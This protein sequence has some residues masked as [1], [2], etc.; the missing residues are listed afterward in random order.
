MRKTFAAYSDLTVWLAETLATDHMEAI[1]EEI[2]LQ[3]GDVCI[4]LG[5]THHRRVIC[6]HL[7]EAL[8]PILPFLSW[9]MVHTLEQSTC[10]GDFFRYRADNLLGDL[11]MDGNPPI[12]TILTFTEVTVT[13]YELYVEEHHTQG[14]SLERLWRLLVLHYFA[15]SKLP[16]DYILT[17]S[18]FH[19]TDRNDGYAKSVTCY[20]TNI[21]ERAYALWC[22]LAERHYQKHQSRERAS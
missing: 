2:Q 9:E 5:S 3:L 18:C 1:Y 10:R 21:Y 19:L 11:Y 14:L 8:A 22:E 15:D 16:F 6:K 12:L 4:P 13:R 17:G 20:D 7:A